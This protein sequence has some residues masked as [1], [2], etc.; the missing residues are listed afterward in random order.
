MLKSEKK[1]ERGT[2]SL[3]SLFKDWFIENNLFNGIRNPF[4]RIGYFLH[5]IQRRTLSEQIILYLWD[6]K[7]GTGKVWDLTPSKDKLLLSEKLLQDVIKIYFKKEDIYTHREFAKN[8]ILSLQLRQGECNS[9][10]FKTIYSHAGLHFSIFIVNYSTILEDKINDFLKFIFPVLSV[11]IQ[12]VLLFNELKK[13]NN[14]VR[15]WTKSVEERIKQGTKSIL[16]KETRYHSL[17]ENATDGIIVFNS[18]GHILEVN[19]S[20]CDILGYSKSDFR[21]MNW[22]ELVED[23][24][25]HAKF[26]KRALNGVEI[27]PTQAVFINKNGTKID[28]EITCKK[29]WYRGERVIQSFIRDISLRRILERGLRDAKEKYETLVENSLVGVFILQEGRIQYVNQVFEKMTGFLR[30]EL[31]GRRHS[32]MLKEDAQKDFNRILEK[33]SK[34]SQ[35]E[36]KFITKKGDER[37]GE[38]RV[39]SVVLNGKSVI[40]GNIIDITDQRKLEAELFENQKMKSI[41][42]LAGGIAHD[43]NNLLGGILG[44]ASLML[45]EISEDHEFYNDIKA[46]ADTTKKAAELTN[47]LL[48]FAR[49]GRYRVKCIEINQLIKNIIGILSHSPDNFIKF[50]FKS[51]EE[52]ALVMGDMQQI[53][54]VIVNICMNSI[55]ASE[56]ESKIDIHTKK[57]S[58]KGQRIINGFTIKKGDYVKVTIR[59][60]G[61]GMDEQTKSRMFEPFFSTKNSGTGI[62]LGL[63]LV[64]GVIKNHEGALEVE[65]SPGKGTTFSFYLPAANNGYKKEESKTLEHLSSDGSIFVVDDEEVIRDVSRKVLEREGFKVITASNGTEALQIYRENWKNISIVILDLVMPDLSGE[66]VYKELCKINKKVKVIFASGYAPED[67]DE[68]KNFSYNRFIQKPFRPEELIKEVKKLTKS[69]HLF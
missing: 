7:N 34:G 45:S 29:I 50:N 33:N 32:D 52:T 28:A 35:F 43:F 38:V 67:R 61:K 37:I 36:V 24:D 66:E 53:R 2:Y 17:F 59:D 9:L 44:Y 11:L 63:A 48:A 12:N 19:K 3:S 15:Q 55:E 10:I 14:Q 8:N 6:E 65:S 49:G 5:E 69:P 46:I 68:L 51:D 41:S 13:K 42:T 40:I 64:Y 58:F 30:G 26:I 39:N 25:R 18:A 22:S 27:G 62:G 56:P 54:Q 20:A 31:I 57:V 23:K 21:N 16:E 60:F 4:E 1:N 47:H